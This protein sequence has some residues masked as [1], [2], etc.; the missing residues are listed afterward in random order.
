[1]IRYLDRIFS[2]PVFYKAAIA[3]LDCIS[4]MG[5]ESKPLDSLVEGVEKLSLG[6]QSPSSLAKQWLGRLEIY[7]PKARGTLL[8]VYKFALA[9]GN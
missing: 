6:P 4:E 1:M 9:S 8:A 7:H 5:A 3:A 2:E